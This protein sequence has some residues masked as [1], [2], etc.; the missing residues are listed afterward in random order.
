MAKRTKKGRR[1]GTHTIEI[2]F[3]DERATSFGG[4]VLEHRLACRLGLWSSLDKRLPAR[5][6]RYSWLSII[7]SAVAGLLTGSRG[8]FATEEV[9]QDE[10]LLEILDL[11]GAPEEATFWRCLDALGGM[12]ESGLLGA[13]QGEW[14]RRI[15]Q[16][17]S[18]RSL[19]ECDGFFPVFA[20]GS[21]LEGSA[22]REG[23]KHIPHKGRGLLWTTI[24]AGPLVAAQAL[25]REGEGEEAVVRRLLPQ[26][27]RE[28]LAP[29][30]LD[31]KALLL[32]DSLHGDEP[33]LRVVE[34]EEMAYIV[35]AGSLKETQRVLEE[36]AAW[37]WHELGA[38][39]KR[40][41]SDSAV[42]QCWIQCGSW[43]EKRLLVGRRVT[44]EGEMF[45]TY[46]G[47]VT[48]LTPEALGAGDTVE[49]AQKVW[50][51]YDAKGRMELSYKELLSDLGL[52]HPPC[53][54]HRRNAGFYALATLAHTV[55]M[56]VKLFGQRADDE[57]RAQRAQ[58]KRHGVPQRIRVKPRRGMR[59]WRVRRRLF[60]LPARVRRHARRLRLEFLGVS[61]DIQAQ[62][63]GWY[64]AISF[65]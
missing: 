23:T 42:C 27:R 4:M 19:L 7:Q 32:A 38:D 41:G 53:Q 60:A 29:L 49:F 1:G 55:G 28:V 11:D 18:R 56:A 46:Y 22:R 14:T 64:H 3:S 24:F 62:F 65:L 10:G 54:E 52:H 58:A 35:G 44:R 31:K 51:L 30:K 40:G 43:P 9:R 12:A 13:T 5:A 57:R 6:G 63:H 61:A 36:R 21:L 2:S 25:A 34:D 48:N 15:L 16:R 50:R 17:F 45:P 39:R 59:L 20:D 47:V 37:E 8:T 26:V 33:T